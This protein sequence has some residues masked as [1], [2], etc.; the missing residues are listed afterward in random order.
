M[1]LMIKSVWGSKGKN[2]EFGEFLVVKRV[3]LSMGGIWKEWRK[4]EGG[5]GKCVGVR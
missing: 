2:R 4:C 3:G 5:M 1:G